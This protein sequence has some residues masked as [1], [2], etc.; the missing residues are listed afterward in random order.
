MI[1]IDI[2]LGSKYESPWR[3]EMICTSGAQVLIV[4]KSVLAN[5]G[6]VPGINAWSVQLQLDDGGENS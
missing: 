4:A 2:I 1:E 5:R 3:E 6:T